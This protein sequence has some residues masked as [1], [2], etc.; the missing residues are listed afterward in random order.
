M[1][2]QKIAKYIPIPIP[3]SFFFLICNPNVVPPPSTA[4]SIY[5]TQA[6]SNIHSK[7]DNNFYGPAALQQSHSPISV[8]HML[9]TII[10]I[11]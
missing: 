8:D 1:G 11:I 9:Y 7:W 2:F 4:R 6:P 10:I 3:K 5:G